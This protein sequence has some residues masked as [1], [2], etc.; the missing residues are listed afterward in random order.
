MIG[1]NVEL[2]GDSSNILK[3]LAEKLNTTVENDR[4]QLPEFVGDGYCKSFNFGRGVSVILTD[5][6]YKIDIEYGGTSSDQPVFVLQYD[7]ISACR[8]E[9][10][11]ASQ[12]VQKELVFA[13]GSHDHKQARLRGEKVLSLRILIDPSWME[14]VLQDNQLNNK[15][16]DLLGSYPANELK[17]PLS[18]EEKVWLQQIAD[19]RKETSWNEF[20]TEI[21]IRMLLEKFI[22][23]I[24]SIMS[25]VQ[26]KHFSE[27][28]IGQLRL[29][30]QTLV[31]NFSEPAPTISELSKLIGMSPS[32]FKND[33]REL[34]GLPVY[35]YFQKS[36]MMHAKELIIKNRISIK[37]A[38]TLVGYTNLSH[39][40]AAFKKEFGVLPKQFLDSKRKTE[41]ELSCVE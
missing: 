25:R 23:R 37:Q 10:R 9:S 7:Q 8:G 6:C 19:H 13:F 40:S 2:Q 36:R 33:F 26:I 28:E 16:F 39:F 34:F 15:L 4:L 32:K 22:L 30:E 5:C 11:P 1:V 41:P 29:A 18:A 38:G 3:Q 20:Y 31:N 21:R 24:K 35:Q 17:L 14:Q 27:Q 12:E